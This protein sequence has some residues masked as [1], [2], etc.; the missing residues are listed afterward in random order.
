M[1]NRKKI[2]CIGGGSGVSTVLSGLREYPYELTA[3]V[4]MFDN[5]GSSGKLR[6]ELGILPLGDVRACLS[7]LAQEKTIIPFFYSRFQKGKLKGHNL[8]NL[9]IAAAEQLT[10]SLENGIKRIGTILKVKG[11][12]LPVATES[13][14]IKV[15]LKNGKKIIGEEEIINCQDVSKVGIKKI[16]L[17]PSVKANPSAIRAI[18]GA[19]LIILAPGKFYTSIIPN[20]LVKG[21]SEAIK[22]SSA[23]KIMI[24][25][26][27]T[28]AGNTDNLKVEDFVK[29]IE[30]YLEK[31]N[32]NKVIFNTSKL[33]P[34]LMKEVRKS[35]PRANIVGYDK[36]LLK[37]ER[38][39]GEDLINR[40]IH[41]PNPNDIL[42][43]G[44]NKRTMVLHDS[45]KLAKIINRI[46]CKQ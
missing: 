15:I 29:V 22:K 21:V 26:L 28:Q 44:Q 12:V 43:R 10:G 37:E 38:F 7:V 45:R 34:F 32:I 17:E 16:S 25:N 13:A 9:I 5:G 8:G 14:H 40:K 11:K 19:D 35:F 23:P 3:I 24:T 27:M 1:L 36:H 41:K 18:K 31:E 20:L 33:S 4:T 2:V 39:V 42:V 30:E 46:L 6:K